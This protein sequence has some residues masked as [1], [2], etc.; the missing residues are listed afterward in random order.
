M[1][2]AP[3][4]TAE[5]FTP[6][7]HAL[8]ARLPAFVVLACLL[9]CS[10]A[11]EDEVVARAAH[12]EGW[13]RLLLAL[14]LGLLLSFFGSLPMTGPLALLVL[15][16][17]VT[18]QRASAFWIAGAGAMVEGVIAGA[19]GTL[20]PLVLRHSTT[21][22]L[23]AR[24]AGALVILIVGMSLLLRPQLV[25]QLRT[26]Q[27]RQSLMAGVLATALNPTLLATWTVTVTALNAN[28]LLDGGLAAG[29]AFAVGVTAGVIA[30]CGL[31]LWVSR[32]GWTDKLVNSR[33]KLGR[34]IGGFL[35]LVGLAIFVRVA[36]ERL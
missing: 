28:G 19:V 17:A 32:A 21:I 34:G 1:P 25:A 31:L 10:C 33:A 24:V 16:R 22:V 5:C 13:L 14:L 3:R 36:W 4:F 29:S 12:T 11:S 6:R 2:S 20:L 15:D 9:C 23:V 27:K 7:R 30:W 26:D 8:A 18:R 35:V